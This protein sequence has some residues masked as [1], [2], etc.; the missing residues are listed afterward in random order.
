MRVEAEDLLSEGYIGTDMSGSLTS[1]A[2]RIEHLYG[3]NFHLKWSGS[4]EGTMKIEYSNEDIPIEL[5]STIT[6]WATINPSEQPIEALEDEIKYNVFNSM[7]RWVRV[8]WEPSSGSATL[9]EF[10]MM[11]K[12]V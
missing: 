6:D 9:T 1:R 4:V 12:G 11:Q 8:V 3:F 7:Y 2:I 5:S 10:W